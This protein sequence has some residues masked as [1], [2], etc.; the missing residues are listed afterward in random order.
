MSTN[1]A[2]KLVVSLVLSEL[3]YCN[4]LLA[5]L[6]DN[7]RNKLQ[8]MQNQAARLVIRKPWYAS[9]TPRLITLHWL[10]VKARI[11]YII[12]CLS[13]QCIYQNSMPLY[14]Y[15]LLNLYYPS[16]MLRSLDTSANSSSLPS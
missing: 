13:F 10:P 11:Q 2:N 3:D 6:P 1:A 4:S 16:R 14:L 5:G 7:K 15:D 12:S 9:G 8:S